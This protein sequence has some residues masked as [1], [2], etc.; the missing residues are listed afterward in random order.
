MCAVYPPL[1]ISPEREAEI[2]E[3]L[4]QQL[5]GAYLAAIAAGSTEDEARRRAAAEVPDWNH[6]GQALV[7]SAVVLLAV[8]AI[9]CY[10]PARRATRVDPV[11]ALRAE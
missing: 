1:D 4:A 5:E 6:F 11:I 3:E 9:A 2:V 10:V 8:T 7:T